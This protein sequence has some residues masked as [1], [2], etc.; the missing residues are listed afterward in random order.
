MTDFF[1]RSDLSKTEA[2]NIVSDT[3]KRCDDG[4]L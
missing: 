2:E 4:E 3:L 1:K